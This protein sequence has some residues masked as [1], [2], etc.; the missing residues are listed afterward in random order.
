MCVD[1][2]CLCNRANGKSLQ[3][4]SKGVARQSRRRLSIFFFWPSL[5]F[6]VHVPYLDVVTCVQICVVRRYRQLE[7]PCLEVPPLAHVVVSMAAVAPADDDTVP[8]EPGTVST[9]L[10]RNL[11]RRGLEELVG[12]LCFMKVRTQEAL[13]A[14]GDRHFRQICSTAQ[15]A[16]TNPCLLAELRAL[17]RELGQAALIAADAASTSERGDAVVRSILTIC[18]RKTCMLAVELLKRDNVAR[19]RLTEAH[20]KLHEFTSRNVEDPVAGAQAAAGAYDVVR[21]ALRGLPKDGEEEGLVR[22]AGVQVRDAV[23][24]SCLC[25]SG[26]RDRDAFAAALQD[27]FGRQLDDEKLESQLHNA[28][29]HLMENVP[30]AFT[31]RSKMRT[32]RARQ[33]VVRAAEAEPEQADGEA[34]D[35]PVIRVPDAP[36]IRAS[37]SSALSTVSTAA[38]TTAPAVHFP[39]FQPAYI[40]SVLTSGF[41]AEDRNCGY[42]SA[43]E[44]WRHADYY[45]YQDFRSGSAV[46]AHEEFAP[47][48][49]N[50]AAK[51]SLNGAMIRRVFGDRWYDAQVMSIYLQRSTG[52][53]WYTVRYQD[54]YTTDFL[55]G[56]IV[57]QG[58]Q[59]LHGRFPAQADPGILEER[60]AKQAGTSKAPKIQ[61]DV[62][63]EITDDD[64][65]FLE[66]IEEELT[67][68]TSK[69]QEYLAAAQEEALRLR[70]SG[71]EPLAVTGGAASTT[72]FEFGL[73]G[74]G[75]DVQSF[76]DRLGELTETL[77]T[78]LAS[79]KPFKTCLWLATG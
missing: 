66:R 5:P 2:T 70:R 36:V 44:D 18:A 38:S 67:N 40:N 45:G 7:D 15:A 56:Y 20:R 53:R 22:D 17:R 54:S 50:Q 11:G 48:E 6:H 47:V 33:R 35:A 29:S 72:E 24:L 79:L 30:G 63:S 32:R 23:V 49:P 58:V 14:L 8:L 43:P 31:S 65:I 51:D 59:D 62:E 12:L 39:L 28:Y 61:N 34:P 75:Q 16:Q 71:L 37:S 74:K 25:L 21:A 1:F 3:K 57:Q 19:E 52:V 60:H 78:E 64:G 13:A 55:P 27:A 41:G 73:D 42:S 76:Y 9:A 68:N 10:K 69:L 46:F 77:N 26:Y 4:D